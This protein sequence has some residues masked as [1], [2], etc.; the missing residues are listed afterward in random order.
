MTSLLN[1]PVTVLMDTF[2]LLC[3][4]CYPTARNHLFPDY[5]LRGCHCN[6]ACDLGPHDPS[7]RVALANLCCTNKFLSAIAT[8]ILYHLAYYPDVNYPEDQITAFYR[9]M[10]VERPDLC[11]HVRSIHLLEKDLDSLP[12][13]LVEA[14]KERFG[15]VTFT[16]PEDASLVPL[17]SGYS[18]SLS[19]HRMSL[20]ML[21]TRGCIGLQELCLVVDF[22]DDIIGCIPLKILPRL[23]TLIITMDESE[24]QLDTLRLQTISLASPSL[25]VLTISGLTFFLPSKNWANLRELT[26]I[27]SCLD[28]HVVK[29]LLQECPV[30]ESFAY[31]MEVYDERPLDSPHTYPCDLVRAISEHT[32]KTLRSLNLNLRHFWSGW[33][34]DEPAE[35]M[36]N[37]RSLKSLEHLEVG[38]ESLLGNTSME[39]DQDKVLCLFSWTLPARIHS[40]TIEA[41]REVDSRLLGLT[42]DYLTKVCSEEFPELET[43][44]VRGTYSGFK[45]AGVSELISSFGESGVSLE[46]RHEPA[47]VEQSSGDQ[48]QVLEQE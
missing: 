14:I 30:L 34:F 39:D 28:I 19:G 22:M 40:V 47:L 10:L 41:S 38:L 35:A 37:F 15:I 1:L 33:Y 21:L 25:G 2:E 3:Q 36:G 48:T 20:P 18:S 9:T 17:D 6:Y 4:H 27:S 13:E 8:P 45:L 7:S 43:I 26:L 46:L 42:L 32:S 11:Q 16:L 5:S 12:S 31:E 24:N 29:L 44:V 23:K